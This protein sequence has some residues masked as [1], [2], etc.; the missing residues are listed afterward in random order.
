M[1]NSKRYVCIHGHFYQPPRENPWLEAVELQDTAAPFHDWNE[2]I[3]FECYAPNAAARILNSEQRIVDIVNNYTRISFNFGPTLLSWMEQADPETY[4]RI[5]QADLDSQSL[6]GGHGS[7]LAQAHSHLILPLCNRRDKETQV[8]WGKADFEHRFGRSP[9]G[10]WLAETAADTETLEVLAEQGIKFTVLAP[11]QAKAIRKIGTEEW[12]QLEHA[13]VETRRPYLCRLP[14][15]KSIA[16]FFYHGGIAQGVAFEGLLNNGSAFANRFAGAF[17]HDAAEPQLVHIATDGES[18]GHHHRHGEMALAACLKHIE[19]HEMATITNY[20]QYLELFPP[21]YEVEIHENSSWSCV[22]G[23]ERWRSNC[24][25]CTGGRPNWTQDWRKP[26]RDQ[27]NWLRDELI[28][29]YE[30]GTKPL[31]KDPWTARDEY[32]QVLLD[33]TPERVDAFIARH[34]RRKLKAGEETQLLR[35]LEMQR[36]AMLMFTSCGWFFDEVS[37]IETN[38]ILQYANRAIY[39]AAQVSDARLHNDFIARLKT[40]PSNVFENAAESYRLHVEPARVDLVRVGMH[41]AASSIFEEYPEHLEFF[42]YIAESEV[43]YRLS[44]GKQRLALGRTTVQSKTTRSEKHFSFAVLY[45]GQQHIIG[46]ISLDMGRERFDEMADKARQ[47]FRSTDLGEVIGLIQQYFGQERFSIQQL[48]RDEK[49]EILLQITESSQTQV[50]KA[51]RDIYED[52]YQLMT[53]MAM[54]DI[55]VPAYYRSALEFV[56]NHDLLQVFENGDLNPRRL[57]SLYAEFRR[58]NIRLTDEQA[59]Q[60][61]VEERVFRELQRLEQEEA[62]LDQLHTLI[63]VLE[64]V[65]QLDINMEYWQS[66]NLYFSLQQAYERGE[67]AFENEEWREAF[68]RMGELLSF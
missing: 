57:R 52:N 30:A 3:N 28:P 10:M 5:L 9:E 61:V 22:H 49:R 67:R 21:E 50:E 41:Y 38:Q 34:T 47:A 25:C 39:Y 4:A 33:R 15:G 62:D 44:A 18:Y 46:N 27:L 45:L 29:I 60:L 54:S 31:L 32:I 43:F 13:A 11:R 20:G 12:Q 19:D 51:L 40:I 53:G 26:L 37:G 1:A 42:N 7:A 64:T 16:L 55:P 68:R 58:W 2:R 14:S 8:A 36:H 24:G 63:R 6:F 65:E 56:L 35:L 17:D 66:Q 59:F 23:V 48:F